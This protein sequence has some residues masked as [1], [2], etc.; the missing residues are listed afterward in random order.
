MSMNK[1]TVE[2]INL[3]SIYNEGGKAQ[4]TANLTA[5]LP[6]MDADMKELAGRTMQKI[7]ALS[8]AEYA[9]LSVFAADEA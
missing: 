9:E 2:E 5:A 3:M 6:F 8:E 4:L 1:L 7:E